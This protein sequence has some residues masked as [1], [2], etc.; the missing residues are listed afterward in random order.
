MIDSFY[1]LDATSPAS[2]FNQSSL[3]QL[4]KYIK[5]L[6][7]MNQQHFIPNLSFPYAVIL[8]IVGVLKIVRFGVAT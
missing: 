1:K 6:K 2:F 7:N 5:P 3:I 8:I 4:T